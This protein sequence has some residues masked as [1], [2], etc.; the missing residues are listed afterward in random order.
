MDFSVRA[1]RHEDVETIVPWTTDTFSWGDYIPE[2]LPGWIDDPESEVLVSVDSSDVPLALCR[3]SMLSTTE[4]WLEGARVHPEHRRVGLGK[5][6]NDAGVEW[7]RERAARVIRLST[8]MSN[9]AARNQVRDLGYREVSRWLY[10]EF[11]VNPTHRADERYRMRTAPSSDTEAAWLSWVS[12]DLARQSRELIAIGFQWR[13]ARPEHLSGIA[14][15]LVQS[16]AGWACVEQPGAGWLRANWVA[17][18]PDD[19]LGLLDG[20]LE[21]AAERRATALDVKL[22]DLP[23]TSEALRRTGGDPEELVVHGKPIY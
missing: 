2:R 10:V 11:E 1:A 7:A 4:A 14:G 6:L 15:E 13:T 18:T 3:V 21:L 8:D 19:I 17:S 16:T 12:S 9:V 5:M 22:P 20:L 23:W